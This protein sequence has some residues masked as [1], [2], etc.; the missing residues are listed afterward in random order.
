MNHVNPKTTFYSTL[1]KAPTILPARLWHTWNSWTF[2]NLFRAKELHTT[3]LSANHFSRIWNEKSCIAVTTKPK[4]S[5]STVCIITSHSTIQKDL[6]PSSAIKRRINT[7]RC[8]I[9]TIQTAHV[10]FKRNSKIK[11]GCWFIKNQQP[12]SKIYFVYKS[13]TKPYGVKIYRNEKHL[14]PNTNSSKLRC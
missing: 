3:I 2:N 10:W 9:S 11:S 6:I 14:K 1:I 12:R 13:A 5:S 8:T 7:R 4:Q